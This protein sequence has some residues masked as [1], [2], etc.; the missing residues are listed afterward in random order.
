MVP[1]FLGQTNGDIWYLMG[2]RKSSGVQQEMYLGHL[3]L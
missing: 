1:G 3:S 2:E